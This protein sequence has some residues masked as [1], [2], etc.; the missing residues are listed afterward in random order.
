MCLLLGNTTELSVYGIAFFLPPFYD[1]GFALV[2]GEILDVVACC[3]FCK[4]GQQVVF[5]LKVL[6]AL[7]TKPFNEYS[8]ISRKKELTDVTFLPAR[9]NERDVMPVDFHSHLLWIGENDS[10]ILHQ[11]VLERNLVVWVRS[12]LPQNLQRRNVCLHPA[13][14]TPTGKLPD[15]YFIGRVQVRFHVFS[16]KEPVRYS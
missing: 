16:L 5:N 13:G 10:H 6:T 11:Q 1:N 7:T 4:Y 14:R 2:N 15:Y 8:S 9:V 12:N 3:A